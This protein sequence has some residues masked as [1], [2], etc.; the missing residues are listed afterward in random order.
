MFYLSK[1]VCVC[2]IWYERYVMKKTRFLLLLFVCSFPLF[3][4]AQNERIYYTVDEMP[5]FFPGT[6]KT[7]QEGETALLSYIVEN[8]SYPQKAVKKKLEGNVFVQFTVS[9]EGK[10]GQVNIVRSSGYDIL[11]QEAVRVISSLPD[12]QPG[13]QDGKAV[14]VWYTLPIIFRLDKDKQ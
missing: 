12:W 8:M 3:S 2:F 4:S 10:V 1:L 11:D 7:Q 9:T 13:Y 5:V 14:N 6:C